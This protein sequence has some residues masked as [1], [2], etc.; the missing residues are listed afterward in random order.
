LQQ[1]IEERDAAMFAS[2]ATRV[3]A[4][5]RAGTDRLRAVK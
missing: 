4:A 2:E 3:V 1:A 5:I